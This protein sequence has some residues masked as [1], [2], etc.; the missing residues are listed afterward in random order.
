MQYQ[1]KGLNLQHIQYKEPHPQTASPPTPLQKRG[2]W[3][4]FVVKFRPLRV[5]TPLPLGEGSG[6]RLLYIIINT[7][8]DIQQQTTVNIQEKANLI[9]AIADKLVG[10]YKP[11]MSPM[12]SAA[13]V[14]CLKI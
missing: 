8:N 3:I 4:A 6:E 1:Q 14:S 7:M 9:W 2:E 11:Q 13:C 5:I 10:V 12:G